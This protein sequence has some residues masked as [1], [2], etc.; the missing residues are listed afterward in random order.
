MTEGRKR[1]G[2]RLIECCKVNAE[3]YGGQKGKGKELTGLKTENKMKREERGRHK[4]KE[5]RE[6]NLE[7]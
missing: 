1:R 2:K 7:R 3:R 5:G 6:R 4:E